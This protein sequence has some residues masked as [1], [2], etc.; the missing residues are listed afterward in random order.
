MRKVVAGFAISLD[1]YI[2]GP[3]GEYDWITMDP[4]FDFDAHMKRFDAFFFG[5]TSYQKLKQAGSIKFPGTQNY[6]FSNSL[7]GVVENCILVGGNIHD[8]VIEIKKQKGKEIAVYGGATLLSSLLDH[9]LVDE[10]T[11]TVMPIILGKGKSMVNDLKSSIRL[12]L[13]DTKKFSSGSV[14]LNYRVGER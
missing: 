2:E 6:I 13:I 9:N 1:G 14:Q 11:M 8:K 10:L 12:I 3:K 7:E 5:R 4:D